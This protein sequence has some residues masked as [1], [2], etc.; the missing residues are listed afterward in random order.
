ME[1]EKKLKTEKLDAEKC[2][3]DFLVMPICDAGAQIIYKN[4]AP[5][6]IRDKT[7]YLFFFVK[8]I[9]YSGQ[10]ERYHQEVEQQYK[11]ADHLLS[12]LVNA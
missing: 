1:I 8:V 7:G 6:G 4:N 2:P 10:E 3:V 5:Y 11:L 12:S 9:K